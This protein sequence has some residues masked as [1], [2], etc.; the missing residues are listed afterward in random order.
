[1]PYSTLNHEEQPYP[2]WISAATSFSAFDFLSKI[3][4]VEW[5]FM[6]YMDFMC[7]MS[8]LRHWPNITLKA[9][10]LQDHFSAT[11]RVTVKEN[12]YP[13][14]AL[15]RLIIW[16]KCKTPILCMSERNLSFFPFLTWLCSFWVWLYEQIPVW[17]HWDAAEAGSGRLSWNRDCILC[18]HLNLCIT[19]LLPFRLIAISLFW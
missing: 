9:N 1:M 7:E 13:S 12:L 4:S 16:L 6:V 15:T 3:I 18:D 10:Y 2:L 19:L 17:E 11:I 14:G 8:I 5:R